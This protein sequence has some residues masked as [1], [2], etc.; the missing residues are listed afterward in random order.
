MKAAA[1]LHTLLALGIDEDQEEWLQ[2]KL[3]LTNKTSLLTVLLDIP[4]IVLTAVY[5]PQL[6]FCPLGVALSVTG[7]LVLNFYKKVNFSRFLLAANIPVFLTLYHACLLK[8][9]EDLIPALYQLQLSLL[10]FPLLVFALN[11]KIWIAC[12]LLLNSSL[13]FSY[14]LIGSFSLQ[15]DNSILREGW[16]AFMGTGIAITALFI[17][18]ILNSIINE[19]YSR[20]NKSMLSELETQQKFTLEALEDAERSKRE[21][22]KANEAKSTFLAT[23]SHEIRTPMNGVIGMAGLLSSTPL[24]TE[25]NEYVEIIK[26][27]GESLLSLI[28]DIL[29]YSKIESGR[30]ELEQQEFDLR[31]CLEKVMDIFSGNSSSSVD[32]IYQVDAEIPE[33]LLGDS[34]RLS[35]VLINLTG[36]ALKFTSKGEVFI[37]VRKINTTGSHTEIRF[38]VSDTGIGIREEKL[39]ALFKAFSQ[40][41]SSTTRKYGGSGLGLAISQRLIDLMGGEI[42]VVSELGS[43]S[44]FSFSLNF[45]NGRSPGR[46]FYLEERFPNDKEKVLVMDD[47]ATLR[48][49]LKTHL[50]RLG[51]APVLAAS[52]KEALKILSENKDLCLVIVDRSVPEWNDVDLAAAIRKLSPEIP[53]LILSDVGDDVCLRYPELSLK[54]I[55]KPVKESQFFEAVRAELKTK[56][57]LPAHRRQD[58]GSSY[59]AEFALNFPLNILL[60]E[61]NLINQKLADRILSKLGYRIDLANDGV[62]AVSL[63]QT[64]TYDLILMD[65]QMPNMDGLEATRTIRFGKGRQPRIVAMTANAMPG[66][67]EAC[68]AAGMD[69][70]ISKP[71]NVPRLL[72]VLRACKRT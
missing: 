10:V 39:P 63:A 22:E 33:Y 53:V 66:D 27:S 67:R 19:Q 40:V 56:L 45:I 1:V 64:N 60:A 49:V 36:N 9:N 42:Q 69:E 35:Q 24:S 65:V 8:P 4:Y 30:M 6:L 16:I 12:T 3:K 25:Q 32:L 14:P 23:M 21:A 29:D 31:A 13:A 38:S 70:Y 41:D 17:I 68:L 37:Q 51:L 55:T 7:C 54:L 50:L 15:L 48:E 20:L 58:A 11:E 62:E 72:E 2:Q 5:F 26:S 18:V 57:P 47:N 34:Y 28:N 61:D 71:V 46:N 44:C 59:S 52:G 43:G